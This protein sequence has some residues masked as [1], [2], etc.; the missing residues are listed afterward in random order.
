MT[1]ITAIKCC[2]ETLAAG[3]LDVPEKRLEFIMVIAKHADR[4]ARFVENLLEPSAVEGRARRIHFDGEI[5]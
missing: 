4:L 5:K 1:P 3:A 2:A